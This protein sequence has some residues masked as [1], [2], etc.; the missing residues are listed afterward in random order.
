MNER[1]SVALRA[2]AAFISEEVT[3]ETG[4]MYSLPAFSVVQG[5]NFMWAGVDGVSFAGAVDS[6]Y[7]EIIHWHWNVFEV[8]SGKTG[9]VFVTE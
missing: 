2:L 4:E 8:P 1:D 9:K 5:L 6:A 3:N 7:T